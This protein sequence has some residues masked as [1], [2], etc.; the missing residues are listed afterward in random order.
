LPAGNFLRTRTLGTDWSSIVTAA[1]SRGRTVAP[2]PYAYGAETTVTLSG[3][4]FNSF[5]RLIRPELRAGGITARFHTRVVRLEWSPAKGRVEAIVVRDTRTGAEERLACR[6][7]IVAAGAIGTP[8]ILLASTSA[9]FPA[10]LGN[11]NG[12]LGRY[13]HDH[14]LGKLVVDLDTSISVL[15]PSYLTR[16]TLDRSPPLYAA[17]CMQWSGTNVLASSILHRKPGRLPWLG[18]SVFGTMAPTRDDWVEI[19]PAR[20]PVN[21]GAPLSLHI[22]H[23]REATAALE[24]ARDDMVEILAASGLK[25]RTRVWHVEPVG[26]SRHYGGTCR[27]HASPSYGM[28]NAW[29][30]LHDVPNVAVVDS[31]AFTTGPEKNPVLTAMTLAARAADRLA[32]EIRAGDV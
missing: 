3:T 26:N 22:R 9:D 5:V 31:S 11:T 20:K 27:M 2:M 25:P 18:F 15:P 1:N 30:R 13:L 14:P 6:A 24:R 7:V 32:Q 23:P 10:G 29:N 4:V 8:E 19:D 17:A 21:G 16:P 12:V 28:L